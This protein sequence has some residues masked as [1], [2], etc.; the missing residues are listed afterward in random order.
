M[1]R[2]G[3]ELAV[4]LLLAVSAS[5]AAA[6][7]W[8]PR[9]ERRVLEALDLEQAEAFAAGVEPSEIVLADGRTLEELLAQAAAKTS[10]SLVYTPLDPC[11]LVRTAGAAGGA[12]TPGA[13]RAFRVRGNLR[14]QGGA[15]GGCG[16]PA[17][18]RALAVGVRAVARGKGS[19]QLGPGLPPNNGLPALEYAA[20]GNATGPALLELCS[21]ED[22]TADFQARANGATAHLVVSVVGYFAPLAVVGGPQGDPGPPGPQGPSGPPGRPGAPGA[23]CT[24]STSAAGEATLTCPDGSSVS[25]E[26]APG[27]SFRLRV[28]EFEIAPLQEIT[29]RSFFRTP[30]TAPVGIK[31]F[32]S[33]MAPVVQDM[34]LYTIADGH[35]PISGVNCDVWQITR[36]RWLYTAHSPSDHLEFPSDD[37]TGRPLGLE[38]AP[39]TLLLLRI[40]MYNATGTKV[41]ASGTLDAVA[42]DMGV[43]YTRTNTYATYNNG[44]DIPAGATGDVESQSCDVPAGLKF[45]RLSTHTHKR[46]IHTEIKD[47]ASV[48]FSSSDWENPGAATFSAPSFLTFSS[49]KLTY[50][51]TYDNPTGNTIF[52]GPSSVT[53]ELCNALA[54]FFPAP[55]GALFCFDGFGPFPI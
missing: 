14:E 26:L 35:Q 24:V 10:V 6:Q 53:D 7:T 17:E 46:A 38:I 12:L 19:L 1:T 9:L 44:I 18:A 41:V 8:S 33:E 20:A 23:S 47:G 50:A 29:Y 11:L 43:E 48:V 31:E 51:C 2:R 52:D 36:G 5:G 45:W 4:F 32:L 25:W 55:S 34:V 27:R 15:I 3:S 42:H 21:E 30:N 49:G 28:P 13:A 22:C 37:G 16:V 39:N 40:H 54:Y